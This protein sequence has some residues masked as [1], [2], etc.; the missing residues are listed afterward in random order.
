MTDT[1]TPKRTKLEE[2]YAEYIERRAFVTEAHRELAVLD[3]ML[4]KFGESR[5]EKVRDLEKARKRLRVLAD[6]LPGLIGSDAA[7]VCGKRPEEP[8]TP[9]DDVKVAP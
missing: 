7:G 3:D 2:T 5:V 1:P 4:E 6:K 8:H 9:A